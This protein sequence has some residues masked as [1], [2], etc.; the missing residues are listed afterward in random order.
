M[1]TN[2]T[3]QELSKLKVP[4]IEM[5]KHQ[6]KLRRALLT[7]SHWNRKQSLLSSFVFFWKGSEKNMNIKRL[8]LSCLVVT[9]LVAGVFAFTNKSGN[10]TVYAKELAQKTYQTVAALPADKQEQLKTT[11]G[12]DSH[13]ILQEAQNAKDLKGF[14]Y[15]DFASSN[16]LPPD[17]DGKLKTLKFL[18]FT[19]PD[20]QVVIL[21]ID[22]ATNLP[23]FGSSSYGN[24]NNPPKDAQTIWRDEKGLHTEGT[25]DEGLK[26]GRNNF[27]HELSAM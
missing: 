12:M 7:S 10:S 3:E 11:L 4:V 2:F 25:P 26:D 15:D 14:S 23:V 18:Q 6:Q 9:L 20:G 17:P 13:T 16:P 19:R 24:P 1:T 21:G 5:K 22:P 8:A 27:W